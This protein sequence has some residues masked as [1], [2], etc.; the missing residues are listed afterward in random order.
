M[1]AADAAGNLSAASSAVSVTTGAGNTT[2]V[3]YK[4]GFATPYIHYRPAG[5]TWTTPPGVAMPDSEV[6]G[7][8]KYTVNLGAA[9]QL[10]ATSTTAAA[11]GTTT[12]AATT[13]SPR[14]PPPSTAGT[15]TAG[16]PVVDTTSPSAP[17]GLTSPSKTATSVSLSWTASTDNVGVT[18]Y[19]IFR[20]GTQVGTH[21]LHELHG[22]RAGLEHHV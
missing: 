13:S 2:T 8:A 9:T 19:L 5:G 22:Q 14:A 11:P 3:Y 1:K 16:A 17:S 12:T 20:G 18:G 7:Y 15:I 21:H 4:K 6:A 10:E